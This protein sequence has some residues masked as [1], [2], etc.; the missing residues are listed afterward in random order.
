MIQKMEIKTI[1][2]GSSGNSYIIDDGHTKILIEC[3]MPFSKIQS[4]CNYAL[5]S[6][7]GCLVTH[8]HQDHCQCAKELA[9]HA[10]NVYMSQGTAEVLSLEGTP[11]VHCVKAGKKFRLGTFMVA[12][13]LVEHDA[14]E[15]LGFCIHSKITQEN[16]MYFTDTSVINYH[17]DEVTHIMAECNY[18]SE[19]LLE[20][21]ERGEISSEFASRLIK[22]HM[23]LEVL[24]E[25]LSNIDKRHLRQIYLLHMSNDNSNEEKFKREIQKVTGV[26]VYIANPQTRSV[27][28]D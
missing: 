25:Y 4:A 8:C 9:K 17:F 3:G 1:G 10:V 22:T 14:P 5:S 26:E 18:S 19:I 24:K 28:Y 6:I 13:F 27:T 11:N 20:R 2:S 21:A 15:P 16:L 12:P 7:S 23:S